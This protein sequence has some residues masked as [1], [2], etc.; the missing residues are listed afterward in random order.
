MKLK[1]LNIED[2]TLL[3]VKY[4]VYVRMSQWVSKVI[5]SVGAFSK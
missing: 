2:R 3:L 5:F 4:I 1:R